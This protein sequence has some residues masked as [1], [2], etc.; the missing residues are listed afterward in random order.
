MLRRTVARAFAREAASE[1]PAVEPAAPRGRTQAASSLFS[2]L[3]SAMES[4][5]RQR[6]G[7]A[8]EGESGVSRVR[9]LLEGVEFTVRTRRCAYRFLDTLD[10]MIW[11]YEVTGDRAL[12]REILSVKST[13][14]GYQPIRKPLGYRRSGYRHTS[15]RELAA[16]YLSY[17]AAEERVNLHERKPEPIVG[18]APP[19]ADCPE[20]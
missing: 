11:V 19:A 4:Q 12:P 17:D 3:H 1:G 2:S 14:E 15:V 10:G 5:S 13:P 16:S 20:H 18:P 9:A 7:R 8:A 6:K